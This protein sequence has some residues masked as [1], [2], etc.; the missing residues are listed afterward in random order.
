MRP[1]DLTHV[2]ARAP[3]HARSPWSEGG[4]TSLPSTEGAERARVDGMASPDAPSSLRYSDYEPLPRY[5]HCCASV[6]PR[7]YIWGGCIEE[8]SED[9]RLQLA[10]LVEVFDGYLEEWTSRD[11]SGTPPRNLYGIACATLFHSLYAYGGGEDLPGST[12][13]HRLDTASME[14]SAMQALNPSDGPMRKVGCGLFAYDDETLALFG[15]SGTPVNCSVP[16][17][18]TQIRDTRSGPNVVCTNEFH[19]FHLRK[20]EFA[21]LASNA[22]KTF[23]CT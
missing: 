22:V 14:W 19:L 20:G 23:V 17:G 2:Y 12:C 15:G 6:G 3:S 7:S 10:S 8:M 16:P 13:V 21:R 5:A 4:R 9:R 1:C 11:V 18:A